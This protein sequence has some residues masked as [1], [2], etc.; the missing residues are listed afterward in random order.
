MAG[1]LTSQ[2]KEKGHLKINFTQ[3]CAGLDHVATKKVGTCTTRL[4]SQLR[5]CP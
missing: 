3:F 2:I 1:D 4:R 5:V